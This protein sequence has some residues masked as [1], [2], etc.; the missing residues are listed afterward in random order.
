MQHPYTSSYFT[1]LFTTSLVAFFTY[2]MISV[3]ACPSIEMRLRGTGP[4][5]GK[6][7]LMASL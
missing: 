2:G 6:F 5:K 7:R 3:N 4:V 1:R